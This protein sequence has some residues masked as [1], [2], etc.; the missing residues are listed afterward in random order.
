[1]QWSRHSISW[2][3][4]SS[5]WV[6]ARDSNRNLNVAVGC[7]IVRA[8]PGRGYRAED[9][10]ALAFGTSQVQRSLGVA[11]RNARTFLPIRAFAQKKAILAALSRS[12]VWLSDEAAA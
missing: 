12:C 11:P 10:R 9:G 1:M 2:T 8:H 3:S 7:P 6:R 4:F 5:P